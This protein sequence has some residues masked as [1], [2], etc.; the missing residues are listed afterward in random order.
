M[1]L[2]ELTPG[3]AGIFRLQEQCFED[4]KVPDDVGGVSDNALSTP[5]MGV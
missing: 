3:F 2:V 5:P 1:E 4:H